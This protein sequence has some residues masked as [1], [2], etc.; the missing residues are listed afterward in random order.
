MYDASYVFN[1]QKS[2]S[3]ERVLNFVKSDLQCVA[4]YPFLRRIINVSKIIPWQ[5]H[6]QIVFKYIAIFVPKVKSYFLTYV[7][8]LGVKIPCSSEEI[9]RNF[10]W[11]TLN[12]IIKTDMSI[13]FSYYFKI[14]YKLSFLCMVCFCVFVCFVLFCFHFGWGV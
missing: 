8:K 4:T 3:L 6:P 9:I 5:H 12:K 7:V 1:V 2:Y 11:L 13:I 10:A 14:R